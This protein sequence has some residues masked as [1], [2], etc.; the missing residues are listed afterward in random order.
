MAKQYRRR[1]RRLRLQPL[2]RPP[3]FSTLNHA[4]AFPH[5]LMLAMGALIVGGVFERLDDQ[6]NK[7]GA[8]ETTR[9]QAQPSDYFQRQCRIATDV[10]EDLLSAVID[11]LGDDNIVVSTDYPHADGPYSHDTE[12]HDATR[13]IEQARARPTCACPWPTP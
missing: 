8:G 7:H 1:H 10:D 3:N 13:M 9:L 12:Q 4:A 11:R 2:P 5:E 6:W